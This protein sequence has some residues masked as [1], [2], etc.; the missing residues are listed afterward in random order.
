MPPVTSSFQ[1]D[2]AKVLLKLKQ[3]CWQVEPSGNYM[4]QWDLITTI[5]LIITALLTP[6]EVALL[7][8]SLDT[9]NATAL[10]VLNRVIDLIFVK[11]M[12][13]NF[14]LIYEATDRNGATFFIKDPRK[15]TFVVCLGTAVP[16]AQQC[17]LMDL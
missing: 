2:H 11:D 7:K 17:R 16:I 15:V 9:P 8:S 6:Y 14:V 5:A 3:P 1:D 10:F 12:I 4:R 13:I